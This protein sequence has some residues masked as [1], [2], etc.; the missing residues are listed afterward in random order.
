[1]TD[2]AAAVFTIGAGKPV[3]PL[4][5]EKHLRNVR[6]LTFD[7]ENA[8]AYWSNDGTRLVFQ[9]KS[10]AQDADQIYVLDLRTGDT[11]RISTGTGRT[12]CAYFTKG[13]RRILFASTHHTGDA[14]PVVKL[15]GRGYQWAVHREYDIF[16]TDV[17]GGDMRQLTATPG[18]DAE[19]TLCPQTGQVVFTSVRDGDLE[20]Y[21]M[22]DD[23]SDVRRVTNRRGYDGG[24]F[25]SHDG[26]KLVLRSA[27]PQSD[28]EADED[29]QLLGQQI[30]RPSH[31]EI[32]VCNRDG[33]DFHQV[34]K[35][36]AANFAP[37]WLPDDKRIIFSSNFRGMEKMR[38][39]GDHT[40]AR[41]FDLFLV[42]EDG[43][44]I[45]QV[46][47]C[48]EFD[49]FPMFSP[50]GRRIAFASN[51]YGAKPGDTNIFVAEWVD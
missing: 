51:R 45:E 47:T 3:D 50:D 37:Y 6:Q 8:E 17:H 20:L 44:G 36:G 34:T 29:T 4:P 28:K 21:T 16:S 22:N 10:S 32:T 12:T 26:R 15:T 38:E 27:F 25:F 43:S 13:D 7:G 41:N 24:A 18:Y 1:M 2:T 39:T 33:S 11:E 48:P 49:S 14:P 31:M 5:G 30:V 40:Q 35:N 46:T 23:G 9:R 42:N 19:A